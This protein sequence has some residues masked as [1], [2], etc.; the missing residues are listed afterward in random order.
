MTSNV[1]KAFE[2]ATVISDML[3]DSQIRTAYVLMALLY[4]EC[5]TVSDF[6][7]I[8]Y[9]IK[10]GVP[11]TLKGMFNNIPLI[12]ELLGEEIAESIKDALQ[13]LEDKS[14]NET[15]ENNSQ[16]KFELKFNENE[17]EVDET[18]KEFIENFFE[19]VLKQTTQANYDNDQ[20][21]V[22]DTVYSDELEDVIFDAIERCKKAPGQVI[23]ADNLIYSLLQ[24][25][26]T[27]AYKLFDSLLT[28]LEEHDVTVDD[29][30]EYI[31]MNSTIYMS[32]DKNEVTI[33]KTLEGCCEVYNKKFV[34]GEKSE[35]VGRDKQKAALWN[36]FSK[37][38]KKN[39]ILIGPA[40]AGKT[41]IIEAITQDIVNETCPKRFIDYTVIE[42]STAGAVAG[43]KY[44]GEF[45]TKV[46]MLKKFIEQTP[47]VI[48]F[49]D[50]IH[51]IVGAG[52]A[53]EDKN[54]LSGAL[55]STL[56]RGDAIVVGTTTY[57]EYKKS[58]AIDVALQRRFNV[59][60]VKEP[61]Y[62]EVKTM[63]KLKIES[64][65]KFHNV[66][67]PEEVLNYVITVAF[68]F[69][70]ELCNPDKT[71][72]LCDSAMA[73]AENKGDA[74]LTREHVDEVY[75]DNFEK[76]EK[77]PDDIKKSIAMHEAGHYVVE[78]LLS[79]EA[80]AEVVAISIVPG[81]NFLGVNILE[82]TDESEFIDTKEY[83][84]NEICTNLAGRAA[85]Q[86]YGSGDTS[87]LKRATSIANMMITKFG[88]DS[89]YEHLSFENAETQS[90]YVNENVAGNLNKK[91]S[92]IITD[93]Y[94]KTCKVLKEHD[95]F[96]QSVVNVLLE[97]HILSK[98]ELDELYNEYIKNK[99]VIE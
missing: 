5:S 98:A 32:S 63:I 94:D 65:E 48:L 37:K 55:K 15:N 8:E 24:F 18:A 22:L 67:V 66:K 38:D 82:V 51:S 70:S 69:N 99:S 30:I 4:L 81:F 10:I 28:V 80:S 45:E 33:P 68:C 44:R 13:A 11:H 39:A 42:F 47:N 40:G 9:G 50:E 76:F 52:S 89:D 43:T 79:H 1:V 78:K 74:T 6:F 2:T 23:D 21:P 75:A 3:C 91:V 46:M 97:K 85:S 36:T 19:E 25:E 41:A 12:E 26:Y 77:M 17:G 60:E 14:E 16:V 96:L 35:I 95:S 61:K 53:G 29:V 31:E 72:S 34:K 87:D 90:I 56:A 7:E 84:L 20:L 62:D 73:I 59:I 58:I 54:D 49:I 86:K 92:R 88:M 64:L 83:Y 57:N 27:S 93:C 71:I